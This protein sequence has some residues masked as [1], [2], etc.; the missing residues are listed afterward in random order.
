[1][2]EYRVTIIIIKEVK[3]IGSFDAS[4]Y[5]LGEAYNIGIRVA[6]ILVREGYAEYIIDDDI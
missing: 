3:S 5:K 4:Q 1:M 2:S 6:E